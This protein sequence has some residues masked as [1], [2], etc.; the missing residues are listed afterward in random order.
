MRPHQ[1]YVAEALP[2]AAAPPLVAPVGL[3]GLVGVRS[4]KLLQA[5]WKVGLKCDLTARPGL[6]TPTGADKARETD[7]LSPCL[8]QEAA[9]PQLDALLRAASVE[10]PGPRY[11]LR[12][13]ALLAALRN[14]AAPARH[15][16]A[17]HA[18]EDWREAGAAVADA[19][20]KYEAFIFQVDSCGAALSICL[21]YNECG[22]GGC[23]GCIGAA[24][25][26]APTHRLWRG[27][28]LL[29]VPPRQTR[30]CQN[31]PRQ[32]YSSTDSG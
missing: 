4:P 13:D 14:V 23:L 29:L 2:A 15:A 11:L 18:D 19:C 16:A 21:A 5:Y 6:R 8:P 7:P 30:H 1:T 27:A 25:Q 12:L 32:N 24:T 20:A 10:P 22:R 26:P 31:L 3:C 17:C 9:R 28:L